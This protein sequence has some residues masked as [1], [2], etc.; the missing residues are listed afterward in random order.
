MLF[1]PLGSSSGGG[2][3]VP[4]G[5][6]QD[7]LPLTT[8]TV[9][10]PVLPVAS[11]TS[12]FVAS[13]TTGSGKGR[14]RRRSSRRRRRHRRFIFFSFSMTGRAQSRSS[15]SSSRFPR[16]QGLQV[17]HSVLEVIL[18]PFGVRTKSLVQCLEVPSLAMAAGQIRSS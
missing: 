13:R 17:S 4:V 18:C 7:A 1:R 10:A 8:A 9:A 2:V 15:A 16:V 14:R 12:A 11:S 3:E 5:L 6:V